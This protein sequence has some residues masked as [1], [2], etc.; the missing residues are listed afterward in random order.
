M[1]PLRRLFLT[2]HR[3]KKQHA[4]ELDDVVQTPFRCMPW[5]I[6]IFLEMNN[7][8]ILTLFDL[9]RTDFAIRCGLMDVLKQER[10][11]LVVAGSTVRYRKRIRAF[12]KVVMKTRF[13][14]IDERWFYLEQLMQVGDTPCCS[15][16]FR[17][18]VTE[19]GRT[20]DVA[21]V[22]A[23]MGQ[24]DK[25]SEMQLSGWQQAWSTLDSER[26]WPPFE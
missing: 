11:G 3:A 6:D 2:V 9:G 7:G 21:R 14:G 10:W 4:I 15:A 1:Y 22:A 13:V 18:G 8:R 20:V 25:M 19:K 26:P 24:K 12:D 16:L 5:D 17:T 23:A